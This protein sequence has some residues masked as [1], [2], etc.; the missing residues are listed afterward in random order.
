MSERSSHPQIM[1][2]EELLASFKNQRITNTPEDLFDSVFPEVGG[3]QMSH[4]LPA[5]NYIGRPNARKQNTEIRVANRL[6]ELPAT[7]Y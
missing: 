6:L 4:Q 1:T 5:S 7:L 2:R 3:W